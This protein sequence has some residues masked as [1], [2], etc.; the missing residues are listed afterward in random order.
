MKKRPLFERSKV[1]KNMND[2]KE[3]LEKVIDLKKRLLALA[4]RK[5]D[6]MSLTQLCKKYGYDLST[7][8]RATNGTHLP[9]PATIDKL[10]KALKA[11]NA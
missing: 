3:R 4:G 7:M 8:S 10:E 11:E 6:P 9:H 5:K 1:V 2:K